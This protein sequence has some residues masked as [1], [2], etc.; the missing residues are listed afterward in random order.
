MKILN[1]NFKVLD[2]KHRITIA[3]SFVVPKNKTES[4]NG[5]AKL[6]VGQ[7][8]IETRKFSLLVEMLYSSQI[9]REVEYFLEDLKLNYYQKLEVR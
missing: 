5:E 6:Y 9:F 4:G 7:D 1:E 3:D 2:T 8:N